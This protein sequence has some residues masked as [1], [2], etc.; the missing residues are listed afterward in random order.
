LS[1][2]VATS[3]SA[4][5]GVVGILLAAGRGVRFGGDKLLAKL[6]ATSRVQGSARGE[7]AD[8]RVGP[9]ACR[10]LLVALPRVVAVV[11]PDDAA[12]AAALGAAGASVVRCA[13]AADGMGA[14]LACGVAAT[15][16]AAGWIVALADMPWILPD[17]IARVASAIADGAPVAAPYY[18]GQRGHPVGFSSASFAMLAALIGDEG[19]KSVVDRHRDSLARIDV[20]DAGTLRDVDLPAD[21]TQ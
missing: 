5:S 9:L 20:D 15:K 12:L 7:F 2:S 8:E 13:S 17:T 11:R 21:L 1:G 6:P 19:A 18:R 14:S 10:H 3:R 16:N 4:A